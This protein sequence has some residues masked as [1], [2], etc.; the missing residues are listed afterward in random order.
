M[1]YGA[2]QY[3]PV[4]H[5][6]QRAQIADLQNGGPSLPVLEAQA[7]D[8]TRLAGDIARR[9]GAEREDLEQVGYLALLVEARRFDLTRPGAI[10]PVA[11]P[12]VRGAML[13][14]AASTRCPVSVPSGTRNTARHRL[15]PSTLAALDA[16]KDVAYIV[17]GE[18]SADAGLVWAEG[19]PAADLPV[20]DDYSGEAARLLALLPPREAEVLLLS[21]G[22]GGRPRTDGEVAE[23]MGIHRT[24]VAHIKRRALDRLRDAEAARQAGPATVTPHPWGTP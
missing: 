8:I 23:V 3:R 10:W 22:F 6:V 15:S 20:A 7:A 13:D 21:F 12:R 24:R 16:T 17:P 14:H 9:T 5:D 18:G 1:P 4:S 11:G 19:M 2:V